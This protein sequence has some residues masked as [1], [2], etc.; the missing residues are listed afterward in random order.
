MWY[1]LAPQSKQWGIYLFQVLNVNIKYARF[2][3]RLFLFVAALLGIVLSFGF[4]VKKALVERKGVLSQKCNVGDKIVD[5]LSNEINKEKPDIIL[6]GNSMLGNGVE[7]VMFER[8]I[9]QKS[10][11]VWLGG[12]N[13][14]WWYLVVKNVI[15]QSNFKPKYLVVFFRD[16]FLTLPHYRSK[17]RYRSQ[18]D[19][20]ATENEPVL[21]R[22][23]YFN[24]VNFVS[25]LA[26]SYIPLFRSIDR[27]KEEFRYNL[28]KTASFIANTGNGEQL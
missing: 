18:I 16:N 4:P 24:D 17:G 10:M 13:S 28:I 7:Q 26:Q 1:C 15:A 22:V 20:F 21:D 23:L 8:E 27:I 5:N 19:K 25:L 6:L 2:K 3:L 11:V 12:S 14:A 9:G